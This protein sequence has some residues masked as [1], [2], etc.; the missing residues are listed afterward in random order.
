VVQE[1]LEIVLM[2]SPIVPH[3]CHAAVAGAGP[4]WRADRRALAGSP[5]PR[6]WPQDTVE[7]VVQVNGKLR[8]RISVPAGAG[9]AAVRAAALAEER[10]VQRFVAG[11]RQP[12]QG[13]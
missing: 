13:P 1:V 3:V 6:R 5:T 8:G 2:L 10:R 12:A 4:R 7:M 11:M 9:E